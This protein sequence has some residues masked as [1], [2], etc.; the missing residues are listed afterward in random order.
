MKTFVIL[1]LLAGCFFA[2]A[3]EKKAVSDL[4]V[5][6]WG[7]CE[8]SE[9]GLPNH[10]YE[11]AKL[12]DN[13]YALYERTETFKDGKWE[14]KVLSVYR[15]WSASWNGE[16]FLKFDRLYSFSDEKKTNV[17]PSAIVYRVRFH[18]D[19]SMGARQIYDTRDS[20]KSDAFGTAKT[21]KGLQRLLE[22]DLSPE[23]IYGKG[24]LRFIRLIANKLQ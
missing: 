3:E 7:A 17:A 21:S 13:D 5:G 23:Q 24:D 16:L 18:E 15:G 4:V 10:V 19:G 14:V 8:L 11:V 20:D 9:S 2:R 22:I 6:I 12:G 1:F